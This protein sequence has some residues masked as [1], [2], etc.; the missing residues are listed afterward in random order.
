MVFADKKPT[1]GYD[2]HVSENR[3]NLSNR[4]ER[5]ERHWMDNG[6]TPRECK[7]GSGPTIRG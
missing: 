7:V 3:R 1:N 4:V 5:N 2:A 6:L